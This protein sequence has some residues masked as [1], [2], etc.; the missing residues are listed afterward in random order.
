VRRPL[1]LRLTDTPQNTTAVPAQKPFDLPQVIQQSNTHCC[2]CY[3]ASVRLTACSQPRFC[4]QLPF[5]LPVTMQTPSVQRHLKKGSSSSQR[6]V[7]PSGRVAGTSFSSTSLRPCRSVC[8]SRQ[9]LQHADN[10]STDPAS[11]R[12]SRPSYLVVQSAP[13]FSPVGGDAR[14]KVIGVGGGGNNALNRMIAS[15]LQVRKQSSVSKSFVFAYASLAC[16]LRLVECRL[17]LTD[18]P[19]HSLL[20]AGRGVLGCQHRCTG[21]SKPCS[22]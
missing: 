14:I 4:K 15:G 16:N 21:P 1:R 17:P 10:S 18:L 3:Q 22:S 2:I 12:Q 7:L 9:Q 8:P 11:S 6:A 5:E 13:S 20:H 19:L